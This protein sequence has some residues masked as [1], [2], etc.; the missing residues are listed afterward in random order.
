LDAFSGAAG[1]MTIAALVDLGVPFGVVQDSVAALGIGGFAL[2]LK[3]ARGGAIGGSKFDVVVAAAQPDRRYRAIDDLLAASELSESVKLLA[4]R[5]FLRLAE[6][7][8][9]VHR[10]ALDEVAFH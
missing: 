6:A 8:S 4:R 5:I 3:R 2:E 7:E 9:E 10:M 1:D